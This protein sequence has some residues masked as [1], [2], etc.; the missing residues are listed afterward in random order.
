V[1]Y[2]RARQELPE[3]WQATLVESLAL[4]DGLGA[5]AEALELELRTLGANQ[6]SSAC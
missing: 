2:W 4:I 6:P 3:P 1:E 5:R